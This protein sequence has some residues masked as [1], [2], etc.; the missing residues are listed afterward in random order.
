MRQ[1]AILMITV[2]VAG[3]SCPSA[4]A[5]S[6]APPRPG[7]TER[8]IAEA[9][10]QAAKT[11]F[12]GT[13]TANHRKTS[14]LGMVFSPIFTAIFGEGEFDHVATFRVDIGV[15]PSNNHEVRVTT[16]HF[17]HGLCGFMF[18]KGK[19]YLVY[20]YGDQELETNICSRT[21]EF[22]TVANGDLTVLLN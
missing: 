10:L 8:E 15:K 12:V 4:F 17:G 16:G 18:E 2:V 11:V 13:V 6:C 20:A 9:R 7:M 22:D 1:I 21:R 19:S 3:I 14:F 5:C